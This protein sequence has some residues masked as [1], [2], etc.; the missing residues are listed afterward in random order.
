MRGFYE[1]IPNT[2]LPV[3]ALL[4]L[5]LSLPGAGGFSRYRTRFLPDSSSPAGLGLGVGASP[6]FG[7]GST[8]PRQPVVVWPVLALALS[9]LLVS[10]TVVL[11]L[12]VLAYLAFPV[13]DLAS[14]AQQGEWR[15]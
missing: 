6:G 10:W 5:I 1:K 2:E 3:L 7:P 12:S 14:L 9:A 8:H 15:P 13:L 4:A 11:A